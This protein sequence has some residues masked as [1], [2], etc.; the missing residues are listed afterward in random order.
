MNKELEP[1]I[2]QR[3]LT[4]DDEPH[5]LG[6][7]MAALK[8]ER[9]RAFVEQIFQQTT[10][11]A[12]ARAAGYTGDA[13]SIATTAWR[14]LQDDMIL[15]AIHEVGER[16]YRDIPAAAKAVKEILRDPLHK[17]RLK[18]AHGILETVR[19]KQAPETKATLTV[20]QKTDHNT[21]L[22]E[23]L[24]REI[25]LGSPEEIMIRKLGATG[26]DRFRKMLEEQKPAIEA[27]FKVIDDESEDEK[28]ARET[29]EL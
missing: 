10:A 1:S 25:A 7:A 8:T 6:A 4:Q 21:V 17:D 5:K 19:I 3:L 20:E 12:A 15:A 11:A 27:E 22:L 2:G 29:A 9:R 13:A 24:R 16:F 14:L 23:W 18:A 28:I 26:Y